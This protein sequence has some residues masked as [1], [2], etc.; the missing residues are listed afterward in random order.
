MGE[1]CSFVLL[2]FLGQLLAVELGL[3][4]WLMFSLCFHRGNFF[5]AVVRQ[6]ISY[7]EANN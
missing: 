3:A 4:V 7:H 1:V 2:Y 5:L 6:N